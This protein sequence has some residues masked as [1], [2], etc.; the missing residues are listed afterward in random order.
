MVDGEVGGE[1]EGRRAGGEGGWVGYIHDWL[2]GI[3]SWL[4][5]E[6]ETVV[7]TVGAVSWG[8][9]VAASATAGGV[10]V[11]VKAPSGRCDNRLCVWGV[12]DTSLWL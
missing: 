12:A 9:R 3:S 2:G 4:G 8:A 1:K 10:R 5:Q 6:M 11:R 7:A